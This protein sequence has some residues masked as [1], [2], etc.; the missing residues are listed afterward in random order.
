VAT[1]KKTFDITKGEK[2]L[3]LAVLKPTPRQRSDAQLVYAKAYREAV[4]KGAMLRT[5]AEKVLKDR[6]LWDEAK[7]ADFKRLT[8]DIREK[9]LALRKGGIRKGEGRDIALALRKLRRERAELDSART[10]IDSTTAEGIAD[11]QQFNYLVSACTVHAD[12]GKPYFPSFDD[13]MG[14]EDDPAVG[15]AGDA[16]VGLLY[17]LD[18]AKLPENDFLRSHGFCDEKLRL[19]N[20]DGRLVSEEGLLV[21]E[22]G[23]YVNE[24]GELVDRD[25]N[26]VDEEGRPLVEA[27]PFLDD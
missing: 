12:S 2:T 8:D 15:K 4:S 9:E 3:T 5:E 6:G 19:V 26:R 27:L 21:N 22:Q 1:N 16:L 18:P 14:R 25:G 7:E 10:A 20:P 23:R 24:A 13:Y 11:N 17:D